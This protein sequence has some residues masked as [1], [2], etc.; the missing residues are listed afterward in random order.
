MQDFLVCHHSNPVEQACS[1]SQ[2]SHGGAATTPTTS[3]TSSPKKSWT[4]QEIPTILITGPKTER[5][6][7]L[8]PCP[9]DP[10]PH[11]VPP[12]SIRQKGRR[13]PIYDESFWTFPQQAR[14]FQYA[15]DGVNS[16]WISRPLL[17]TT[18]SGHLDVA[19]DTKALVQKREAQESSLQSV[20]RTKPKTARPW[21]EICQIWWLLKDHF[22][23][24]FFQC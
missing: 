1:P 8:L 9:P 23:A 6:S 17:P 12:N 14:S 22:V 24:Y 10:K 5:T 16:A 2:L 7:V 18:I 3:S 21:L 4:V 19:P 15:G 13:P 20:S 11:P